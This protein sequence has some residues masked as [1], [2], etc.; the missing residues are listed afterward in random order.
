M[1]Q[2]KVL[3]KAF[4]KL[5]SDFSSAIGQLNTCMGLLHGYANQ[6]GLE[7]LTML[8][9]ALQ[10]A[11]KRLLVTLFHTNGDMQPQSSSCI[12]SCACSPM[13]F[14]RTQPEQQVS[15]V[16]ELQARAS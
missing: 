11:K 5:V 4:V 10:A 8:W 16:P 1:Q 6:Q 7:S 9:K 14:F 13:H 2:E 3:L 12:Q 15:E